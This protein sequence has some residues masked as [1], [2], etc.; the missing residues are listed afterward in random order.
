MNQLVRSGS[1]KNS[2]ECYKPLGTD[3]IVNEE[4]HETLLGLRELVA[5]VAEE[6]LRLLVEQ[7]AVNRLVRLILK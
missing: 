2:F 5:P 7:R 3:E 1:E 4:S 6:L